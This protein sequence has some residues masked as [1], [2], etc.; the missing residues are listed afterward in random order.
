MQR[1]LAI[2]IHS[3]D[4]GGAE[5]TAARM[6][7]HWALAGHSVSL[8]TLDSAANDRYRLLPEVRRQALDVMGHSS[9]PVSAIQNNIRRIHALRRAI[10][11]TRPQ[12]VIA[13]TDKTNVLTLAACR[14]PGL[15]VIIAERTDPRHHRVGRVWS[16][17][18]ERLYPHAAALVVQTAAVRDAVRGM[19]PGRPIYVIPNM[20]AR[21]FGPGDPAPGRPADSNPAAGE[22]LAHPFSIPDRKRVL[23]MGRLTYEKGFDLLI[24][25]FATAA[26]RQPQWDLVICG[27]GPERPRLERLAC[28]LGL[29]QRIFLPGWIDRSD[30]VYRSADLFVL[31]SRYEGFPNALLEAMA[32]GVPSIASDCPSGPY[33][34]IRDGYNGLLVR[35]QSPAW[36]AAA[37]DRLMRDAAARRQLAEKGPEVLQRFS[38]DRYYARWEAVLDGRPESDPVFAENP[39]G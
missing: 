10:V 24:Q 31:P 39:R 38:P 16:F 8:I 7:N 19:M 25:A 30:L 18:R 3:L 33:E 14:Q 15:P 23:G 9:N 21:D 17:L 20:I 4:G 35:C 32:A 22:T 13:L 27:E 5:R 2:V 28:Q 37:M 34:I 11:A 36:L 12:H 1:Q 6:A 26:Q 29:A